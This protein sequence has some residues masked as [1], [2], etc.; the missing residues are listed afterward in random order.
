MNPAQ[1]ILEVESFDQ[2]CVVARELRRI[3]NF[4]KTV[5]NA[6]KPIVNLII[7]PVVVEL[8][9]SHP[10]LKKSFMRAIARLHRQDL[11]VC[12]NQG[13]LITFFVVLSHKAKN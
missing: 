13:G 3:R 8:L 7:T 11:K 6:G 2:S 9:E 1:S 10:S 5:R 4:S 12:S